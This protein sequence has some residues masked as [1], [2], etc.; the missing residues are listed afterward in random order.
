LDFHDNWRDGCFR[1]LQGEADARSRNGGARRRG[2]GARPS[3]GS[4]RYS[5]LGRDESAK[6][7]VRLEVTESVLNHVS[8]SRAG[9]VGVYQ[10]HDYATEK[11]QALDAWRIILDAIVT[12]SSPEIIKAMRERVLPFVTSLNGNPDEKGTLLDDWKKGIEAIVSGADSSN[13]VEMKA[14]GA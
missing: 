1:L 13:V 8:G 11:R 5:P 7:G 12:G 14:R 3:L 2:R 9:I 6:L 10:K 4:A